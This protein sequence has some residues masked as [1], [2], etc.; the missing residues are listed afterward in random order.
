MIADVGTPYTGRRR[1]SVKS[2]IEANGLRWE[3]DPDATVSILDQQELIATGSIKD[4]ILKYIVVAPEYQGENVTAMVMSE[5]FRLAAEKGIGKLFL[6]TK[7]DKERLF[8]PFGFYRVTSTASVLLLENEKDGVK[9]FI[10]EMEV[11]LSG[12]ERPVGAIVANANPFTNGHAFLVE[13]AAA[14]CALVHLFILSEEKSLFTAQERMAMA[15]AAVGHLSNVRIH[16]T[17]DYMVS[18]VT[19]PSYFQK[20]TANIEEINTELDL[21]IFA[22]CFARPLGIARR[23]VGTEP[24]SDVTR[25]YN[26]QMKQILPRYG[27]CVVEI[28]RMESNG[29]YVSASR[30]RELIENR[31]FEKIRPLVPKSTLDRIK[32]KY[33]K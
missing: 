1:E 4:N 30:V 8:Q 7:P 14:E 20:E 16:P 15:E 33:E 17:G 18:S 25:K 3:D 28:E 22:E 21:T 32:E 10:K 26:A 13:K 9:R 24:G 5:L 2:F 11:P 31:E 29:A 27:I 19:F 12:D 6:F 23:Y